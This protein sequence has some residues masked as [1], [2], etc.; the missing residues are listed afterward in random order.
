MARTSRT[1]T[2]TEL[3]QRLR[4]AQKEWLDRVEARSGLSLSEIARRGEMDPSTLTRFRNDEERGGVLHTLTIATVT[5][6][7]GVKAPPEVVGSSGDETPGFSDREAEKFEPQPGD[8]IG[9]MVAAALGN[10]AQVFAMTLRSRALEYVGYRAGDVLIV[11]QSAAPKP[12]DVVCAQLLDGQPHGAETVFRVN[13][14]PWI[15]GA[16]PGA[17]DMEP[18]LVDGRTVHIVGVVVASLRRR[19]AA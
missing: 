18:R 19:Q 14:P 16:G 2:R 10:R 15:V 9:P 5:E 8:P 12:G 17:T 11:D 4:T 3:H 7:T 6:V 1:P 13:R